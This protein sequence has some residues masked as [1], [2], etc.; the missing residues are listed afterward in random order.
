MVIKEITMTRLISVLILGLTLIGCSRDILRND[1]AAQRAWKSAVSE[2]QGKWASRYASLDTGSEICSGFSGVL[3]G[4]SLL[5]AAVGFI[6]LRTD[7]QQGSALIG[8]AIG[9]DLL[10]L[11]PSIIGLIID[12]KMKAC[13]AKWYDEY[14]CGNHYAFMEEEE[15]RELCR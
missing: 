15:F 12:G 10:A 6:D 8:A 9:I 11:I 14:K 5:T 2:S 1:P 13:K 3:I 7:H 4:V